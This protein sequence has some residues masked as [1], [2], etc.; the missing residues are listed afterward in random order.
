MADDM[1]K[2][3]PMTGKRKII[4][5]FFGAVALVLIAAA[6]LALFLP[7]LIDLEGVKA[8]ATAA[9]AEKTGAAVR[10]DQVGLSYFPRLRVTISG[11]NAQFPDGPAIH[12]ES[13]S[14]Y[15]SFLR[16]LSG[17]VQLASVLI[18]APVISVRIKKP[19]D[20][21][22]ID[23]KLAK[24]LAGISSE[25][26]GLDVRIRKG[27]VN[28]AAEGGA[29]LTVR[30]I[31]AEA[32]FGRMS[33]DVS[34]SGSSDFVKRIAIAVELKAGEKSVTS[35]EL[36]VNAKEIDIIRARDAVLPLA[37]DVPVIRT[38]FSYLRAGSVP[39]LSV[40]S[41]A[42]AVKDLGKTDN[43]IIKG[44]LSKGGVSVP[45]T[46][47]EFSDV[48]GRCSVAKGLLEA[49][50]VTGKLGSTGLH[51][52]RLTVGV[53][54]GD[55]PFRLETDIRSTIPE[56]AGITGKIL[57]EAPAFLSHL[58]SIN[59]PFEGHL[60]L[61]ESTSIFRAG[62]GFRNGMVR[63]TAKMKTDF[64]QKITMDLGF[65][66]GGGSAG[67]HLEAEARDMDI[68]RAEA[69][70]SALSDDVPA[71]RKVFA[72][73][74]SG[75]VP[76]LTFSAKGAT[77]DD[78]GMTDRFA[79]RGSLDE[80]TVVI[81]ETGL[82]FSKV[83]GSYSIEKGVLSAA[84]VKGVVDGGE[85]KN[86]SLKIGLGKGDGQFHFVA[87]ASLTAEAAQQLLRRFV[88]EPS[89][90][91][92]RLRDLRGMVTGKVAVGDSTAAFSSWK[93]N[94]VFG[95][96][97]RIDLSEGPAVDLSLK[98]TPG[99]VVMEKLRFRDAQSNATIS[100]NYAEKHITGQ[101]DG[102][103]TADTLAS[104][105]K[106]PE[107]QKGSVRGSISAVIDLETLSRSTVRGNLSITGMP[108]RPREGLQLTIK[109]MDLRAVPDVFFIDAATVNIGDTDISLRGTIRPG[110]NDF[111]FDTDLSARRIDW[112]TV[113]RVWQRE[114]AA[115][116]NEKKAAKPLDVGGVIRVSVDTFIWDRYTISPLN[117]RVELAQN[118]TVI[119][120]KDSALCG[121][122]MPGSIILEN[123]M[124]DVAFSPSAKDREVL[125]TVTCLS[126]QKSQ[127]SGTFSLEGDLK[128]RGKADELV[129]TLNGD[130]SFS[131]RKGSI[132]KAPNLAR[133]LAFMDLSEI[134]S[135]GIPDI[136][137]EQF[138]YRSI[139]ARGD[140]KNGKLTLRDAV[141]DAPAFN[142]VATGDIDFVSE[143]MDVK[144]LAA[145]LSTIDSV[146]KR[147][148]IVKQITGGSLVAVPVHVTG[149][150]KDLKISYIPLSAVGS[151]LLGIME[152]TIKLPVTIFQPSAPAGEK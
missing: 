150:F 37:G 1:Q 108:V 103:L 91:L 83:D 76:V 26:P 132:D 85:L 31:D 14:L 47:L 79:I 30:D 96:D 15:P 12:A 49:E 48:N 98:L 134:F 36:S 81:P 40:E 27:A 127:F 136:G 23:A 16:L 55:V 8:K 104:V 33:A 89:F 130:L 119:S 41:K 131:A 53:Q 51:N 72:Y 139:T 25:F 149:D 107:M 118:K 105:V 75:S 144:L 39:V 19:A 143:T 113:K 92:D 117:A 6:A 10:F 78:L 146:I 140:I 74:P 2:E 125:P 111:V 90:P 24:L 64:V 69:G 151:G 46:V 142:M 99:A 152:R 9:I 93:E 123:G 87:D 42:G 22:D 66:N 137:K 120:V 94:G 54:R 116:G 141:M 133:I 11:V 112:A 38:I 80:G 35:A 122:A 5:F 52:A 124:I 29:G 101:Y 68:K 88:K 28:L 82:V 138:P 59:G 145:P 95:F 100:L 73:V 147:I 62:S 56:A 63:L 128:A 148:P 18:Q 97:G 7:R 86:A 109:T 60:V 61:G 77:F 34:V 17:K 126:D 44:D 13:I 67:T 32:D 4:L 20:E 102:T 110:Q 58:G 21:E 115:E 45:N 84:D 114:K 57:K 135:G 65:R 106:M 3:E 121:I 50:K 71:L 43:I 129:R 70:L